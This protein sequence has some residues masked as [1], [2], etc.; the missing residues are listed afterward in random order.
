LLI[1]AAV[2]LEVTCG[3]NVVYED[4]KE[5]VS[6][7]DEGNFFIDQDINLLNNVNIR[8]KYLL[9]LKQLQETLPSSEDIRVA[10]RF[11]S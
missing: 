4:Y 1:P 9:C 8:K 3:M 7:D 2:N 10:E 6:E 11:T 5:V